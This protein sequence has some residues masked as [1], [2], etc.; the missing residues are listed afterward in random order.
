[1]QPSVGG[2]RRAPDDTDLREFFPLMYRLHGSDL[3]PFG[4]QRAS[5]EYRAAF[6]FCLIGLS[7][8]LARDAR[9]QEPVAPRSARARI[10]RIDPM[11]EMQR[12][13]IELDR[14][15]W[16][17][18]GPMEDRYSSWTSHSNRL[19]PV[20]AFGFQFDQIPGF[21]KAYRSPERLRELYGQVPPQTLAPE[22]TYFD[23]VDVFLWQ[24]AA[25]AAGK[26]HLIIVIFDGMDWQI[27]QAAACYAQGRVTHQEGRGTGL[28]FMDY[29]GTESSFGYCVT[30]PFGESESV[31][32]DGQILT[33]PVVPTGGYDPSRG[34]EN[35][36]TSKV[37]L[38]YL[39]GKDRSMPHAVTDSASSATSIC[40]GIK[41]YNEA[42]NVDAQGKPVAPLAHELQQNR[43]WS[44]GVVTSVPISH[45]T[46]AAAFAQNVSREDYQDLTRDMLGLPSVVRRA[47]PLSGVDVLIGAGWGES[48][49]Q[50]KKQGQNFIPG[51]RYLAEPDLQQIQADPRYVVAQRSPGRDG[52]T[53]LDEAAR[54]AAAE[55]RRLFGFFGGPNGHLPFTT[56]D[57]RFDPVRDKG[58]RE[59]YSAADI[60]ENPS[61]A[62]MTQAAL[63][64]LEQDRDGFWL[65]VEAGDVDWACHAN[66]LDNA[67]GAA[68]CG[69][70][71]V[72]EIFRW[73][74]ERN[75]WDDTAVLVTAD[76]GH[77]FVT[78]D[79]AAIAEAGARA[80]QQL[81]AH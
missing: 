28:K 11:V 48:C 59:V 20:Y 77:L 5:F 4:A 63:R 7:A 25:V 16:G 42:I 40:A 34:G 41:T 8:L 49:D 38:D 23:Q 50:D 53:V 18:W 80:Q 68:I 75:G 45:A 31:D 43:G 65:M 1:M 10:E 37:N 21:G 44:I 54:R 52:A 81:R 32:V 74:E 12:A 60:D 67:I 71:A 22:A 57:G 58:P 79:I 62:Q 17:H 78:R 73:V 76:H 14:A 3:V 15:T 47:S 35:P 27:A 13:A 6:G 19:I 33:A 29:C 69:D 46:P 55:G 9:S 70:E 24:Q 39:I 36:W 51:N 26:K 30:S 72:S 56:A 2:R 66:N 64:V 61:L